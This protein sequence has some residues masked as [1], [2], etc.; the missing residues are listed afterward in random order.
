MAVRKGSEMCSVPGSSAILQS[1]EIPAGIYPTLP[2]AGPAGWVAVRPPVPWRL[3]ID[4]ELFKR[5]AGRA[6]NGGRRQKP[7]YHGTG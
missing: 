4:M 6:L 7:R 3:Y 1:A 5:S 2:D